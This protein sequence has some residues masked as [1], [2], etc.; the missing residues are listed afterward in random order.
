MTNDRRQL[1][2]LLE[3][4]KVAREWMGSIATGRQLGSAQ[5]QVDRAI[6]ATEK[7]VDATSS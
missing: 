6:T 4:A 5:E 2:E 7:L 3:A 1:L